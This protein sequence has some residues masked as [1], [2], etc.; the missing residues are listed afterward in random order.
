MW[1]GRSVWL[2]GLTQWRHVN[3]GG[4]PIRPEAP[5]CLLHGLNKCATGFTLSMLGKSSMADQR[6]LRLRKHTWSSGEYSV[7]RD[8]LR[9]FSSKEKWLDLP[10]LF[11]SCC[12]HQVNEFCWSNQGLHH[13]Q[14][15]ACNIGFN[16]SSMAFRW[17][18]C[19]SLVS[20]PSI[21]L[22][23]V[24]PSI[25]NWFFRDEIWDSRSSC[26]VRLCCLFSLEQLIYLR[27]C[28]GLNRVAYI[29]MRW[30]GQ[31]LRA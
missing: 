7:L 21:L 27:D 9:V 12:D 25:C 4:A 15:F 22:F 6:N 30:N 3:E 24:L 23:P 26:N 20:Y 8:L 10:R 11:Q 14:K 1:E 19:S 28:F 13:H 17:N 5:P 16:L 29:Q 18:N 31:L 2:T